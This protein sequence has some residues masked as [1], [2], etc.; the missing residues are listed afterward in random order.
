V[1]KN[2]DNQRD[3][4]IAFEEARFVFNDNAL[5]IDTVISS[6]RFKFLYLYIWNEFIML[7][8]PG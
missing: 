5:N 6:L 2:R 7:V 1:V 8:V 4:H 3:H